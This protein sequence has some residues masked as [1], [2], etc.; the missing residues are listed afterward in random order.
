MITGILA[1][2]PTG[3]FFDVVLRDLQFIAVT[4][5]RDTANT[6]ELSLPQVHALNCLK[7][8]FSDTRFGS[9]TEKHAAK[10]LAI[11]AHCL[12]HRT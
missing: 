4:L 11:A 3:D 1:A 12:E 9:S 8:V 10:T 5:S 7:E 2:Y 6:E